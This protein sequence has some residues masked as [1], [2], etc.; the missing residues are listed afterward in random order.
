ML[1]YTHFPAPSPAF[2]ISRLFNVVI[3]T[4]VRWYLVVVLIYI[5]LIICSDEHIFMCLL[6]ISV[7]S[8][9]KC[10][11]RPSD[12]FLVG[13]LLFCYCRSC[14]YILEI[15]PLLVASFANIF[16][17]LEVCLFHFVYGFLC[18]LKAYM[19]G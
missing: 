4:G 11:F 3:L 8:L 13:Y 17:E 2:I 5:Y 15:K 19:L 10:L 9:E 6:A 7:S 16:S 14:L 18:C 1:N 12:H